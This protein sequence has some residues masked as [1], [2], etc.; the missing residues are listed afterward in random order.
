MNTKTS[1]RSDRKDRN[2]AEG[3]EENGP[4]RADVEALDPLRQADLEARVDHET[5]DLAEEGLDHL[6]VGRNRASAL[7]PSRIADERD[8]E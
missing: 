6:R 3:G 1:R 7:P 4:G 8:G 5:V 2:G